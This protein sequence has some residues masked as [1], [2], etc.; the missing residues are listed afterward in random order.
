M[1][2]FKNY[3][4]LGH[5]FKKLSIFTEDDISTLTQIY[6]EERIT[7]TCGF[8]GGKTKKCRKSRKSRKSRKPKF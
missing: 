5:I 3:L 2:F 7:R 1:F 4:E 8:F 6:D